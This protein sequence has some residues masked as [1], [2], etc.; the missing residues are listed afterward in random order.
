[1]PARSIERL[2]LFV[3]LL[4][5]A[6]HVWVV[7]Y[8]HP[9]LDDFAYAGAGRISGLLERWLHEYQHWNGRWASNILVLR[10]P[11]VQG[12]EHG[13]LLYRMVP[14]LLLLLTMMCAWMLVRGLLG[15][16]LGTWRT[17]IAA[18][19]F[20]ALYLHL[21]P[22][23]GEGFYWYTGAI[24]YQLPSALLL[25]HLYGLVQLW[26]NGPNAVTIAL[27]VLLMAWVAGSTEVH[28]VLLIIVQALALFFRWRTQGRVGSVWWALLAW[29]LILGLVMLLAPGNAVRGAL[30]PARHDIVQTSIYSLLQT[31]RFTLSWLLSPALLL[32]SWLFLGYW[33]GRRKVAPVASDLGLSPLQALV[34][35]FLLVFITMVPPYW[36]SG[37]LGQHRTVNVALFVFLPSWFLALAVWQEQVLALRGW[38]VASWLGR[39]KPWVWS[40]LLLCL[41]LL[42]QDGKVT[43]ELLDGTLRRYDAQIMTRYD[44][45]RDAVAEGAVELEV[46]AVVD[47]PAS[48]GILEPGADPDRH[49]NRSMAGYFGRDDLRLMVVPAERA[50]TTEATVPE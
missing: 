26:R 16:W 34:L 49:W 12:L 33:S 36:S 11:L 23:A 18:A 43:R 25:F 24:S 19:V 50:D 28:M 17:W 40:A 20:L 27:L 35:P 10:G 44:L 46:P 22:H 5:L 41:L 3:L 48:L 47:P 45:I 32:L 9:Y 13:L 38:A 14:V 42:R 29:A 8:I 37:M 30:F 31:G 21:M 4:L 2:I 7:A 6:R 15:Q 1:M 39:G